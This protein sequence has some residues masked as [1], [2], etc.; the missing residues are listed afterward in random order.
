MNNNKKEKD[1][2]SIE[3]QSYFSEASTFGGRT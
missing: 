1:K 3:K 2:V